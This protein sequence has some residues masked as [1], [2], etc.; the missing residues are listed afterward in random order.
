MNAPA[1]P[2]DTAKP[3]P[4][5]L[6][7][8]RARELGA[9]L[10]ARRESLDPKRLGLPRVGR[11]RTPGLRREEVA[12]LANVGVTWYTW[13]EQGRPV[14]ASARVLAAIAEALQCS[15][16]ET[17]HLFSLAGLEAPQ[18]PASPIC[19]RISLPA[20][21]VLDQLDPLP[22]LLQNARFDILGYN[23]AYCRMVGVDLGAVP[24]SERN[25]IY[26]AF[27]NPTWRASIADWE[28]VMPRMVALFRAAMAEHLDDPRW[29]AQLER[30][31]G[32][33]PEFRET[34]QRY[35]VRGVENLVKT[36]RHPSLGGFRL[37]QFNWWSAPKNGDRLVVYAPVDAA[38]AE[39]LRRMAA[40]DPD[41][42]A[43]WTA[44]TSSGSS[45]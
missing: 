3:I 33:S 24:E 14:R 1:Q 20:Q 35:E 4:E 15:V 17:R 9:F 36:F 32:A 37:Q 11:R 16:A 27:T 41:G 29:V 31:R 5:T 39:V 43:P 28:E 40:L 2:A 44:Q 42:A 30:I 12:Q 8:S 26:L 10:R 21:A 38:D 6:A 34:W 22:A 25:C 19:E 23:R 7:E 13:L 45:S 18:P